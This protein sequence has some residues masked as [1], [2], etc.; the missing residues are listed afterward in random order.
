MIYYMDIALSSDDETKV[1]NFYKLIKS[2][3]K[4][5]RLGEKAGIKD[6]IEGEILSI[7]KISK[8]RREYIDAKIHFPPNENGEMIFYPVKEVYYF[9]VSVFVHQKNFEFWEKASGL[10]CYFKL[11][12]S[13]NRIYI[14]TDSKREFFK[15]KFNVY[16]SDDGQ[17]LSNKEICLDKDFETEKEAISYINNLSKKHKFESLQQIEKVSGRLGEDILFF[18]QHPYKISDLKK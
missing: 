18:E 7:G 6:S 5:N 14:N 15:E 4:L 13:I 17:Y 12:D 9:K 2:V 10:K 8:K 3:R 11:K 1:T 16:L